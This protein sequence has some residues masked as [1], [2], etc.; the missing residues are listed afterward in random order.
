[1][2][3]DNEE[4][5]FLEE[6][7]FGRELMFNDPDGK[8][9][10]PLDKQPTKVPPPIAPSPALTFEAIRELP[11][12]Q[13]P[14]QAHQ[15][16][17]NA[18]QKAPLKAWS[19]IPMD[20]GAL[21]GRERSSMTVPF[22]MREP[23][24][25]PEPVPELTTDHFPT[26]DGASC[27]TSRA[28]S[29][30]PQSGATHPS[31]IQ[32]HLSSHA[33]FITSDRQIGLKLLSRPVAVTAPGTVV[34]YRHDP[35][36]T[37]LYADADQ[38]T[39]LAAQLSAP[40]E[41]RTVVHSDSAATLP[42]M[43]I[44]GT[45]TQTASSTP[46]DMTRA[47]ARV[48]ARDTGVIW[49]PATGVAHV[50][51]HDP[52]AG[53]AAP[54][55]AIGLHEPGVFAQAPSGD[56]TDIDP[57]SAVILAA[58]PVRRNL[59]WRVGA[60]GA[61]IAGYLPVVLGDLLK[62]HPTNITGFGI[63][64][65]VLAPVVFIVTSARRR[66]TN[67]A[68]SRNKDLAIGGLLTVS[69]LVM[70]QLAPLFTTGSTSLWRPDLVALPMAVAAALVLL[71]GTAF[72]ADLRNVVA[73]TALGAPLF[74]VALLTGSQFPFGGAVNPLGA[75]LA[76]FF[77]TISRTD[78]AG[79][80]SVGTNDATIVDLRSLNERRGFIV[81]VFVVAIVMVMLARV[82]PSRNNAEQIT[83]V[84]R[85]ARKLVGL[86]LTLITAVAVDTLLSAVGLVGPVLAPGGVTSVITSVPAT[87]VLYLIATWS[88]TRW[89]HLLGLHIPS[90]A[91]IR[92]APMQLPAHGPSTTLDRIV[93][94]TAI[95]FLAISALV[96][97]VAPD[98]P[99][100]G[101]SVVNAPTL[102]AT[103]SV[104]PLGWTVGQTTTP[105]GLEAYFGA[106]SVWTR[107]EL[108]PTPSTPLAQVHVDFVQARQ[109]L[110]TK[111]AV[112]ATYRTG[113][114]RLLR[115]R[116]VDLGQGAHG[117]QVT[118]YDATTSSTWSTVTFLARTGGITLKIT[119]SATGTTDT[120]IA[121]TPAA[122]A[123]T[124]MLAR[125][126]ATSGLAGADKELA[127]GRIDRTENAVAD[128]ARAEVTAVRGAPAA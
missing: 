111:F 56:P 82:D 127:Q 117:H 89:V 55:S 101:A 96:S 116:Q 48:E 108:T 20:V 62:L 78:T 18:P 95:G 125:P 65:V 21:M 77:Q 73:V 29:P 86:L 27:D 60:I 31:S 115:T 28:P 123:I 105:Q 51:D 97:G 102:S 83:P 120:G 63:L 58:Q 46:P 106:R 122:Q 1:M 114:F 67:T 59:D 2:S 45:A 66:P 23:E 33:S 61:L 22:P 128:L 30:A 79:I 119:V 11:F 25:T 13:V 26:L 50:I 94:I 54:Q 74:T 85:T 80:F 107:L 47:E 16:P 64:A 118:F 14:Q 24:P 93:V 37:A 109:S 68:M 88:V 36:P 34:D 98:S 44:P 124:S 39:T 121:P 19:P 84:G 5:S 52:N 92:R 32:T 3:R 99:I 15:A 87:V 71:W 103:A 104:Y 12:Q 113:A 91:G 76:S 35:S 49:V 112:G 100:R 57:G 43:D 75:T 126:A 81:A 42:Q 69:A 10:G 70:A 110:L 53:R 8:V 9:D 90:L 41:P 72:A 6:R 38:P 40:P 17:P 4:R 7:R